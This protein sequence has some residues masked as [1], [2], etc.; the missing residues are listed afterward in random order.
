MSMKKIIGMSLATAA[1]SLIAVA[2]ISMA[3]NTTTATPS[4]DVCYGV[5]SCKGQGTD[6]SGHAN[7]CKGS[8]AMSMS[9]ADC[10]AKGGSTTPPAAAAPTTST[11]ASGMGSTTTTTAQ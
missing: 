2:P 4:T 7:S 11:D 6:A 10:A 9:A 8:A 3:D 5:N 1:A